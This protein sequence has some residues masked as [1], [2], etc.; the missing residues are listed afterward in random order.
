LILVESISDIQVDDFSQVYVLMLTVYNVKIKDLD[1]DDM[2][3]ARQIA[4]ISKDI[5]EL[6]FIFIFG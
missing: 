6:P 2:V 4:D 3:Y 1:A 5:Y